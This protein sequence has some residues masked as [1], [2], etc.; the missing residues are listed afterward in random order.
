MCRSGSSRAH[1]YVMDRK[2]ETR[3]SLRPTRSVR[4]TTWDYCGLESKRWAQRS[5]FAH[6]PF[7]WSNSAK[8]RLESLAL[9][10]D[11]RSAT[12]E[13]RSHSTLTGLS[14]RHRTSMPIWCL[15]GRI[16]SC[17]HPG[18]VLGLPRMA[19]GSMP[20][21]GG[22]LILEEPERRQ[23]LDQFPS[24]AIGSSANTPELRSL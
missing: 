19:F 11:L 15:T 9:W 1:R 6:A 21:D 3:D 24:A 10:S 20:R 16:S 22:Y 7:R 2:A 14:A 4:E 5:A 13:R 12:A 8:A 23:L 18:R 17:M